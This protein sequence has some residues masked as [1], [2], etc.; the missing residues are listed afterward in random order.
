[1]VEVAAVTRG[2]GVEVDAPRAV[3]GVEDAA[4]VV[5]GMADP[6]A[7]D[8]GCGADVVAAMAGVVRGGAA[9]AAALLA[10]GTAGATFGGT[11]S[12]GVRVVAG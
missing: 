11:A 5:F 3:E 4:V 2:A 7:G 9:T 6:M 10:A 12:T 1:M 8:A